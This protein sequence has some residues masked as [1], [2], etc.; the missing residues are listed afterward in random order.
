MSLRTC[1]LLFFALSVLRAAAQETAAPLTKVSDALAMTTARV[2]ER[3]TPVRFTGTLT[4]RDPSRG[5]FCVQDE[6]AGIL[7][8]PREGMPRPKPGSRVT[9][10]G[11][12]SGEGV[13]GVS[14]VRV[15][16]QSLSEL[17]PGAWPVPAVLTPVA[18]RQNK[19]YSQWVELEANIASAGRSIDGSMDFMVTTE[20]GHS[21]V[22]ALDIPEDFVKPDWKNATVKIRGVNWGEGLRFIRVPGPEHLQVVRLGA[23]DAFGVPETTAA[24]L[25]KGPLPLGRVRLRA[26]FAAEPFGEAPAYL[27]GD[28]GFLAQA[29]LML[30]SRKGVVAPPIMED[31][32][33]GDEVE[34]SGIPSL[35]AGHLFLREAERRL[36]KRG[37]PPAPK[38]A[39]V[40][41]VAEGKVNARLVTVSGRLVSVQAN[42]AISQFAHVVLTLEQDGHLTEAMI[43]LSR[44]GSLMQ[45]PVDH[46]TEVTGVVIP[47][48]SNEGPPRINLRTAADAKSKQL[49]FTAVTQ[50]VLQIGGIGLAAGLGLLGWIL[51]LRRRVKKQSVEQRQTEAELRKALTA[52]RDL[53]RLKSNFVSMVSHEFRTPLGIISVSSELMS[54]YRNR[55]KPEQLEEHLGAITNATKRMAGMMENILVLSRVDTNRLEFNPAPLDLPGLCRRLVD[56]MHSITGRACPI[57]FTAGPG[58]EV[59]ARADESILRHILPNLLSNA[60]KYSAPDSGVEFSLT[61]EGHHAVFTVTDHGIGIS[62]DDQERLFQSFH[63]GANVGQTPGTGLG[64]V[65]VRRCVDLH[66]G[67]IS[68]ASTPG[69]GSAF[70]VKLPLFP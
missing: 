34:V 67:S 42:T 61:R 52:E 46:V 64:L 5:S 69:E 56:E 7:V 14:G 21:W 6:S 13:N 47:P 41:E 35:K 31:A 43:F 36:L 45:L 8:V 49:A 30:R 3:E 50:R 20:F 55:L 9:V 19:L 11:T 2:R 1:R 62:E 12:L 29:N 58:T 23:A 59:P 44:A 60:C 17:G 18:V 33:P 22:Q 28:T 15:E 48:H 66:G 63:R 51:A 53:S 27:S 24:A 4:Y 68:V 39:T 70:T 65:I 16:A 40:Q 38:P 25:L 54:R 57:Q 37:R 10:T 26:T 32:E